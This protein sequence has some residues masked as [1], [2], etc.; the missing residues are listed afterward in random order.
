MFEEDATG[1]LH[2]KSDNVIA[3]AVGSIHRFGCRIDVAKC[4][5]HSPKKSLRS[6]QI[7]VQK[8]FFHLISKEKPQLRVAGALV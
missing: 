2:I 8:S 4:P 3:V 1:L 7:L 6:S 5:L